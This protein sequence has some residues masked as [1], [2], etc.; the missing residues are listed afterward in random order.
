M[1]FTDTVMPA[2]CDLKVG[3]LV[4]FTLAAVVEAA[5]GTISDLMTRQ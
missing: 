4:C 3:V 2:H 5:K 1:F